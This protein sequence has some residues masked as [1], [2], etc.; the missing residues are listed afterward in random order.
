MVKRL[1]LTAL[2][3]MITVS[4][5]AQDQFP[6]DTIKTEK[7]EL[8]ITFLGHA[9]LLFTYKGMRIYVDPVGFWAD[10]T[11]LPTA[12]LIL[13]TQNETDHL[14]TRAIYTLSAPDTIVVLPQS[15]EHVLPDGVEMYNG[16]TKTFNGIKVQAVPAYNIAHKRG[17]GDAYH[18]KG[19]GNGYVLTFDDKRV[20]VASDTELIPEM[21]ALK[22]IDVAFLPMNLPYNMTPQMAAAAVKAFKPKIVYPYQFE[23]EDPTK[24]ADLLKGTKGVEVRIRSMFGISAPGGSGSG[25][26]REGITKPSSGY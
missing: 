22:N 26:S 24:L 21:K 12:D 2:A 6:T 7:S 17:F 19:E 20:Y 18:R 8:S 1:L 23:K 13:V 4:A 14:D 11:R 15:A 16:D 9:S 25:W 10:Y 3:L 5:T